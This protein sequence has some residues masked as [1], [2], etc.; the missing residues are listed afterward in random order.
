MGDWGFTIPI[1]TKGRS[2]LTKFSRHTIKREE[3]P[4]VVRLAFK[5]LF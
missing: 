1:H 5:L 3:K 2:A 4:A